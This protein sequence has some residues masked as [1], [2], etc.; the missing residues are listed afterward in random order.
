[1]DPD[2]VYAGFQRSINELEATPEGGDVEIACLRNAVEYADV[3][4]EWLSKGGYAP[5]WSK[6]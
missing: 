2:V 6:R 1:M 3:L 4:F 5:D